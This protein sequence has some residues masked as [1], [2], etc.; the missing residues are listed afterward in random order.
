MRKLIFVVLLFSVIF[1][2]V[3]NGDIICRRT[4]S[5][6][7]YLIEIT[8]IFDVLNSSN[9]LTNM[10]KLKSLMNRLS[11]EEE[12][13]KKEVVTSLEFLA[14]RSKEAYKR[15]TA[16]YCLSEL[17]PFLDTETR[18]EIVDY[19]YEKYIAAT[20]FTNILANFIAPHNLSTNRVDE[21]IDMLVFFVP[22]L[23]EKEM[24]F[25]EPKI[26]DLIGLRCAR[27]ML[28]TPIEKLSK[29]LRFLTPAAQLESVKLLIN[30]LNQEEN[31][32]YRRE[33]LFGASNCL[34]VNMEYFNH[35]TLNIIYEYTIDMLRNADEVTQSIG[36][37]LG[38]ALAIQIEDAEKKK[39]LNLF[40][41]IVE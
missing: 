20:G 4:K 16:L 39:Q 29:M 15:K 11:K 21:S 7:S 19:F 27:A 35:N 18:L 8:T 38:T 3:D 14:I 10:V 13:I 22:N 25:V 9:Q 40:M 41:S 37:E 31:V 17:F 24:G 2:T 6:N 30:G 12:S 26:I 5:V 36:M 28:L 33:I 1:V 23:N 34:A 32:N